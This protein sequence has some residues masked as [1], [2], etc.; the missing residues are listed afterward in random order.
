MTAKDKNAIDKGKDVISYV[1]TTLQPILDGA[2][3]ILHTTKQ[4]AEEGADA[5]ADS[6]GKAAGD[7]A[8]RAGSAKEN[9]KTQAGKGANIVQEKAQQG[10]DAVNGAINQ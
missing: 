8:N 3:R 2:I 6:T 5:A 4:R 10:K 9:A 1:Q 7:V